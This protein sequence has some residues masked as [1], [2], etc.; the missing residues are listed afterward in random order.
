MEMLRGNSAIRE[1]IQNGKRLHLFEYVR[2]AYV[3]YVGEARYVGHHIASRPDREDSIR[4]VIVF[5]LEMLPAGYNGKADSVPNKQIKL[6]RK[7]LLAE[8]RALAKNAAPA[9][10][11][12]KQTAQTV[13]G[14][15]PVRA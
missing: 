8:L 10:A 7:L 6:S 9:K 2:K 1:H 12:T 15:S 11:A 14:C 5:H 4:D 13:R 3:S